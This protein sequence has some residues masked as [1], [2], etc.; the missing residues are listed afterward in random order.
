MAPRDEDIID[1]IRHLQ[2]T[3][4]RLL[5]D[6]SRL[7]TPL[8]LGK[9]YVWRPLT[10]VYETDTDFV[11]RMDVAG[12]DPNDF[13]VSVHGRILT[14]RGIRHDPVRTG[15]KH[16]HKMEINVGAFERNIEI[17]HHIGV[18]TVGAQYEN[19]FLVVKMAKGA[20]RIKARERVVPV[21][22]GV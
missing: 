4:E 14:I 8:L 16:F 21:D 2:E 11:I 15:H 22:R 1:D 9:D 7:R 19:G 10:D 17:P 3:M 12:M 20:S 6:F 13:E 18:S 5:S